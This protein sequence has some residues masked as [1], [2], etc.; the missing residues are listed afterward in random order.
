[1][2]NVQAQQQKEVVLDSSALLA[3]LLDEL[4]ADAVRAAL[5]GSVISA[6]TF[7]EV[8]TK[9]QRMDMPTA[10]ILEALQTDLSLQIIPF[11]TEQAQMAAILFPQ[12]KEHQLSFS[13]RSTLALALSRGW[14]VLSG[15][16]KWTK[17]ELPIPLKYIR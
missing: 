5:P 10:D 16:P 13:D 12:L 14:P 6:P 2:P 11:D 15:D 1:M 9:L 17:L 7:S 8:V 4:G 3:L